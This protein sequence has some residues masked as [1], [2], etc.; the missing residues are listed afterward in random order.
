M[1]NLYFGYWSTVAILYHEQEVPYFN[2]VPDE[3][4]QTFKDLGTGYHHWTLA[5]IAAR[6]N[7]DKIQAGTDNMSQSQKVNHRLD[8]PMSG[9]G[10]VVDFPFACSIDHPDF[11]K[12]IKI[13][14]VPSNPTSVY[15]W[16]I[17]RC[18]NGWY[19]PW[20]YTR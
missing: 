10:N 18:Y 13:L 15:N 20:H 2:I 6:E 5:N 8:Y 1:S 17:V 14:Y 9:N 16:R 19:H 7:A 12:E 4:R 11:A 3:A